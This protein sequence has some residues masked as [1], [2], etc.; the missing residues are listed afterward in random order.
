MADG[1]DSEARAG[2][3]LAATTAGVGFGNA[4]VHI[5]HACSYP[6]AGLRHGWKP[7]GYPGEGRFVP[8]GIACALTAPAAFGLTHAALPERHA[9]A[10]RLLTGATPDADDPNPLGDAVRALMQRTGVPSTLAEVGYAEADIPELVA[11]AEKQQRLLACAPIA[12][13]ADVLAGVFRASI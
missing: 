3:M 4:G 9:D 2:M 6:I 1:Q 10:A 7:P 11:G 8:H 13:G 5:P 12:T